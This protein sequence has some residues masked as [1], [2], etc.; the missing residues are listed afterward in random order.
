[1]KKPVP[2]LAVLLGIMLIFNSCSVSKDSLVQRKSDIED[3][4]EPSLACFVQMNDGTI[5]NYT[6]LTLVTGVFITPHLLADGK[7]KIFPTEIKAYQNKEHYAI[8][9]AT[10]ASGRHTYIAVETLPGFAIRVA[11]GKV[12]VYCKQ[13]YNGSMTA[14]EF[15]LQ[16][17]DDGQIF[18]YSQGLVNQ[19]I[20]ETSG[21][22]DF[23]SSKKNYIHI[24]KKYRPTEVVAT[25]ASLISKN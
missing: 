18:A 22:F 25:D 8:S 1:M 12:N 3:S 15:F 11:K 5:R 14:D 6:S 16:T 24:P 21:E 19:L 20:K 4:K 7:I 17:G 23:F 10:F 9:Q 13:Y 2:H